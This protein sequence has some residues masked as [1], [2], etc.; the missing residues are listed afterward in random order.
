MRAARCRSCR[1]GAGVYAILIIAAISFAKDNLSRDA[2][3][4]GWKLAMR[5][6]LLIFGAVASAAYGAGWPPV[7]Q[8]LPIQVAMP[9]T[10]LHRE[11][12]L[13]AQGDF[14]SLTTPAPTFK[15]SSGELYRLP[16]ATPAPK[17][18]G[19]GD[20]SFAP[21]AAPAGGAAVI[22]PSQGAEPAAK[23][24]GPK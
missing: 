8:H 22:V 12:N 20:E 21:K 4:P 23:G 16:E 2:P 14:S 24:F 15:T 13:I 9:L 5:I 10:D 18:T 3:F 6:E 17:A 1:F 7:A 11:V 19:T